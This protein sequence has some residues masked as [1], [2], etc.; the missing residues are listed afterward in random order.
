[1]MYYK[2]YERRFGILLAVCDSE[3][4]DKI[5]NSKDI[6]FYVN[7]RFYRDKEGDKDKIIELLK[8]SSNYNLVG[9]EAVDCGIKA[10]VIDPK[11][12]IKIDKI[13]HAQG[14]FMDI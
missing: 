6:E 3:I 5:L 2:I 10:G 12:I 13:P 9:K 14:I 7:P 8:E 1:M 4:C 11:R